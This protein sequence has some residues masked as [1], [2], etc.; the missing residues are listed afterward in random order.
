MYIYIYTYVLHIIYITY[1]Y[2][3]RERERY[4][5]GGHDSGQVA[6][7]GRAGNLAAPARA[8]RRMD[9]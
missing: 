9:R 5:Y 2:I 3:Y 4:R 6:L 7:R 8:E 1:I